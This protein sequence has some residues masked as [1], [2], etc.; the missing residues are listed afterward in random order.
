MSETEF[1]A[2]NATIAAKRSP[3]QKRL[4]LPIYGMLTVLENKPIYS[5]LS[6]LIARSERFNGIFSKP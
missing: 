5:S 3:S 6:N 4:I 1:N 2:I